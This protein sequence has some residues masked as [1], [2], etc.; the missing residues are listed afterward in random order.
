L[1]D[2]SGHRDVADRKQFVDMELQ[3]DAEHQEDDADFGKLLGEC[4][5]GDESRRVRSDRHAGQQ[6]PDDRRQAGA[7]R[8]IAEDQCSAEATGQRKNQIER[9]H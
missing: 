8:E 5:I 7:L 3:A 1:G 2:G 6:V 9:V 4:R